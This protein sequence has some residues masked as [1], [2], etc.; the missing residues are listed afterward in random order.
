MRLSLL[1][2]LANCPYLSKTELMSPISGSYATTGR[3]ILETEAGTGGT[4][5]D[6][7]ADWPELG[8]AEHQRCFPVSCKKYPNRFFTNTTFHMCLCVVELLLVLQLIT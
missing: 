5:K 3:L 6:R 1:N 7:T 8:T 4:G 2:D